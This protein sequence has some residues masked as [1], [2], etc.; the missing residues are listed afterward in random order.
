MR[1]AEARCLELAASQDGVIQRAQALRL[2]L[3]AGT[4]ESRLRAKRWG[5]RFRSVYWIAGAPPGW[6]QRLRA[7]SLWAGRDYAISH[8]AAAAL[9]GLARFREGPV[10][11][12]VTRHLRLPAP[13]VV[14]QVSLLSSHDVRDFRGMRVTT[15]AR[16]L[17][18]LCATE[19]APTLEATADEMLR[20]R[21]T[22]LE[23]LEDALVR[24]KGR[25]GIS[26]LRDL[27]KRYQAG[28]QPTE[29]ELESKALELI[30]NAG[31][32][33]PTKQVKVFAGMKLRRV[34]FMYPAQRIIVEADSTLHHSSPD[35]RERDRLRRNALTAKGHRVLVWTWNDLKNDADRL[36]GELANALELPG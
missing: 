21:L 11:V 13:A 12:S 22:T 29:S 18:D 7:A 17:V 25:R 28:E 15:A 31:L 27:V 8:R 5:V 9:M 4:I 36:A 14:H 23:L 19:D 32:P 6:L 30:D 20:R 1:V 35:A 10:E 16:T 3:S 26:F 2:G 34:D 24:L 33:R